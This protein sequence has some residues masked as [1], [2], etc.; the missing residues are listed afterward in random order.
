[1]ILSDGD[2]ASN[3]MAPDLRRAFAN[4]HWRVM[5]HSQGH[6]V[7][8]DFADLPDDDPQF[9]LYKRCGL[10][11]RD[12]ASILYR[13]AE[14]AEGGHWLDI[15]S[16][17]GWSSLH[18]HYGSGADPVAVDPMLAVPD[19][20]A[21]FL[22]NVQDQA[23]LYAGTSND[24]FSTVDQDQRFSGVMIDGDHEPGKP[25][26]DAINAE[27]HLEPGGVIVFHDFVGKPV[28][29]AVQ[30]LMAH[31]FKCRAYDTPHGMAVCWRKRFI[32]PTHEPDSRVPW[33]ELRK[34]MP[35]FPFSS[36]E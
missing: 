31:G 10:L 28:R 3:L 1:M 16:H 34:S 5:A 24:F 8:S 15:G 12:E 29:D 22:A 19:F 17:T 35:D 26:E 18:L 33:K 6:L 13:I 27:K 30:F 7:A 11:T 4:L 23:I 32:P 25:L 36:C 14:R 21:R 2:Y 9:G 20:K